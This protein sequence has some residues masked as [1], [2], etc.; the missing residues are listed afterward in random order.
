M[1]PLLRT[2]ALSREKKMK[3]KIVI[4]SYYRNSA[5]FYNRALFKRAYNAR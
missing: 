3:R 5:G 4:N 1:P 2:E